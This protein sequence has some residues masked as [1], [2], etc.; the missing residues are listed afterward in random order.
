MFSLLKN[1][2]NNHSH[3]SIAF[4]SAVV[5]FSQPFGFPREASISLIYIYG[6]K[7]NSVSSKTKDPEAIA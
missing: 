2:I 7:K 4:L 3:I 6:Q 5:N 1:F